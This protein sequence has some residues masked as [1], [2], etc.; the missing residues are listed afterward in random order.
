MSLD[1]VEI[2]S[3]ERSSSTRGRSL[4]AHAASHLKYFL[5]I[6][7]EVSCVVRPFGPWPAFADV[8]D[9][10]RHMRRSA[11]SRM[12][13]PIREALPVTK[14]DRIRDS[15]S[16]PSSHAGSA[17]ALPPIRKQLSRSCRIGKADVQF[18]RR[19]RVDK[20]RCPVAQMYVFDR[21]SVRGAYPANASQLAVDVITSPLIAF[22]CEDNGS[23]DP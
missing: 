13:R 20:G 21:V 5:R 16:V 4:Y 12:I 15:S 11:S 14:H 18:L 7:S 17:S 1:S 23:V 3:L 19:L 6:L 10:H 22:Y 8:L 9:A 2:V